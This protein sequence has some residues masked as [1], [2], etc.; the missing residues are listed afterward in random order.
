MKILRS[1]FLSLVSSKK[2]KALIVINAKAQIGIRFKKI[3]LSADTNSK[4]K[5][6]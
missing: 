6:F 1:G 4:R 5:L 3:S 2:K